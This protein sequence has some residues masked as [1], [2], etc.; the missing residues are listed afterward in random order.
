M[1]SEVLRS[2]DRRARNREGAILIVVVS[3]GKQDDEN[4]IEGRA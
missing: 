2:R 3:S 4:A 1:R